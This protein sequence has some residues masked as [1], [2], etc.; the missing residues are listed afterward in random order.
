MPKRLFPGEQIQMTVDL[1]APKKPGKYRFS[2]YLSTIPDN[3]QNAEPH[4]L[5]S[6]VT[7]DICVEERNAET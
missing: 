7:V 5:S 4:K 2:Y 1:M 6:V 3:A